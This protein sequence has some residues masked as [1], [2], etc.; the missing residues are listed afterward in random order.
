MCVRVCDGEGDN[1][2]DMEI[3]RTKFNFRTIIV[4]RKE[5]NG[6]SSLSESSTII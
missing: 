2:R 3:E 4:Y 6:I 1:K 5:D